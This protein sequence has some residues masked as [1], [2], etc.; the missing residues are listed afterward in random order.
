MPRGEQVMKMEG[1]FSMRQYE[2][3]GRPKK[4]IISKWLLVLL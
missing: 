1:S 2:K 4:C 3:L